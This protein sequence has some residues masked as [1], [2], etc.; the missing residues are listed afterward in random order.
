MKKKFGIVLLCGII[1]FSLCGCNKSKKE[2]NNQEEATVTIEDITLDNVNDFINVNNFCVLGMVGSNGIRQGVVAIYNISPKFNN[3]EF[4]DV[5]ITLR[6]ETT[7]FTDDSR[8]KQKTMG[9]TFDEIT[10]S[11][12]GKYTSEQ[13]S[14]K[15]DDNNS[16]GLGYQ[17]TRDLTV[18]EASGKIKIT[19]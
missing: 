8:T 3:V 13:K 5:K 10:L 6:Y 12:D 7:C 4:E 14:Y 17:D 18:I 9:A 19:E 16:C 2:D 1:L 15:F 11:T